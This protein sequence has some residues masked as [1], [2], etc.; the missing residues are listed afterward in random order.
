MQKRRYISVILPLKLEWLPCYWT[1]EDI[2][3]GDRVTVS[4]AGKEYTGVVARTDAVPDIAE[5]KIRKVGRVE[6][7]ME[8]ILGTEIELWQK[9]ADY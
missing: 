5:E 6:R 7:D 2:E 8:R 9:V 1:D 3:V 4:F